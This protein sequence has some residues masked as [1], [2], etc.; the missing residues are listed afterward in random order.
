MFKRLLTSFDMFSTLG[1]QGE[2]ETLNLYGGVAALAILLFF[3]DIFIDKAYK[4][5]TF[6][7]SRPRQPFR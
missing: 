4:I 7:K 1:M 5:G 6:R 3:V 2:A